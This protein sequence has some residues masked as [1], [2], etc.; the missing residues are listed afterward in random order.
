[1]RKVEDM[2]GLAAF[3]EKMCKTMVEL[4]GTE[5][6][7]RH[8][9]IVYDVTISGKRELLEVRDKG[10]HIY[11]QMTSYDYIYMMSYAYYM[12]PI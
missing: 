9:R 11:I 2:Q 12:S 8:E 3:Y 4:S 7:I 10:R 1:M 6:M 5:I